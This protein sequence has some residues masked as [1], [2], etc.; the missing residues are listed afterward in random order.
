MKG[1]TVD[2]YTASN[3]MVVTRD[4]NGDAVIGAGTNNISR[5]MKGGTALALAEFFQAERDEEL[6]RWRWPYLSTLMVYRDGSPDDVMVV[7]EVRPDEPHRF[8]RDSVSFVGPFGGAARAYFEAHP[9]RKPWE[10]AQPGEVWVLTVDGVE[11]A[12]YPSKSMN[13]IFTA[14]APATGNSGINF[15]WPEISDGRRIYPEPS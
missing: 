4:H 1:D 5:F 8:S 12:F 9:E 14:V 6:G 2:K 3:G 15:D 13:R 10:D 7:D 11:S